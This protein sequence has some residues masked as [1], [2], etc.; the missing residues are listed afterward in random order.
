MKYQ[1]MLA[2]AT[3]LGKT[4]GNDSEAWKNAMR[5]VN[6]LME[7][8]GPYQLA[9]GDGT[10][11]SITPEAYARIEALFDRAVTSV[12]EFN[13]QEQDGSP[14]DEVRHQLMKNFNKE[15]LAKSFI[16]YK[17][18]KPNP[19]VSLH[20]SMEHFR[21]QNVELSNAELQRLGGNLSSRVQ[22]NVDI[23]GVKT[24]GVFTQRTA[25]DPKGQFDA[26]REEMATKYG[27]FASFF[28]AM[29]DP[30]FRQMG[31]LGNDPQFFTNRETGAVYDANPQEREQAVYNFHDSVGID[32]YP[33]LEEE[34]NKY[35]SDPDF[36]NALFDYSIK[37]Q[38]LS[39]SFTVNEQV[40][41]L[42]PG[43][44]IDGRNSAMSSVANLLGVGDLI[45]K[46]QQVAV[47]M[48]S[49]EFQTGTF[50]EFV[51]SKDATNLDSIDEM[52]IAPLGAYESKDVKVQLANLQV[53]DYICG[54]AD[55]HL[56]NM[57]YKFDSQT[58]KLASI[59]GIDNDAS[60]PKHLLNNTASLSQLPSI[61]RMRVIDQAMAEKLLN[62]D[63]GTLT[64]T[65]HGYGLSEEAIAAANDRLHNLQETI[66][67]APIYDPE[68][69]LEPF[70]D[71]GDGPDLTIVKTEDWEKLSLSD[72]QARNN[73][74]GKVVGVQE[75]LTTESMIGEN[76]QRDIDASKRSLKSMLNPENSAKLL[77]NAQNHKPMFGA[78]ERYKNVLA[79]MAAYQN[80]PSPEDPMNSEGHIKWQ[81]LADLKA[82]V[83]TY[84]QEK[85]ALGHLNADGSPTEE[86]K[87]KALT[88]I[89]D[90]DKIDKFAD[91]LL[92]QRQQAADAENALHD[93]ERK[94]AELVAFRALPPNEQQIILD[95]R[96]AH[97]AMLNEDLSVRI[98]NDLAAEESF[99]ISEDEVDLD[100]NL[101]MDDAIANG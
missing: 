22:L 6:E 54:N 64:A 10:Y 28:A 40:L 65:L 89:Q 84:K 81:R 61:R 37:A 96:R 9:S 13:K 66:R 58:H 33:R 39:T 62:L 42:V 86:M 50:M 4:Q 75:M 77:E 99:G 1:E 71:S 24:R 21:Y 82:A 83:D 47:K 63:E 100:A 78:S 55:R 7:V 94:Q 93:A 92:N 19:N 32:Q 52:R 27:K 88:R 30:Q 35:V 72:L 31:L 14:E 34:F 11:R 85:I 79:A 70:S 69:G 67:N 57:L 12:N 36:F 95:Q 87:G 97:E 5:S 8:M 101:S 26:L 73:Y 51:E 59:K 25:Y 53:L 2:F 3:Y 18:V 17:N 46:S 15:F 48:P 68:K 38:K 29:D 41:D 80:A 45:A 60:F 74:F 91:L 98:Q 44:N 56:G 20:D 76:M 90:V 16:E 23:N 49:G 43:E